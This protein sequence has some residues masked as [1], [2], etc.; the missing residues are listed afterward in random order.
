MVVIV[1]GGS[2]AGAVAMARGGVNGTSVGAPFAPVIPE[3]GAGAGAF[4][5]VAVATAMVAALRV[6]AAVGDAP[7]VPVATT[8]AATAF[9]V[10]VAAGRVAVGAGVGVFG[11][12]K[13]LLP[14]PVVGRGTIVPVDNTTGAA[15]ITRDADTPPPFNCASADSVRTYPTV[16]TARIAAELSATRPCVIFDGPR[17]G[18]FAPCDLPDTG[19]RSGIP[20]GNGGG[21]P[22]RVRIR[23]SVA[24]ASHGRGSGNVSEVACFTRY[25]LSHRVC[26][27]SNNRTCSSVLP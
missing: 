11:E 8:A 5:G 7:V 14:L 18:G 26:T 23:A 9:A 2:T 12:K 1:G 27:L 22:I 13:P 10:G 4:V 16:Y 20:G 17:F 19:G 3:A 24:C 15:A 25:R 21:A 6:A